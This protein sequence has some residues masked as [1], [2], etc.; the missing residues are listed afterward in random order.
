MTARITLITR[1]STMYRRAIRSLFVATTALLLLTTAACDK[2]EEKKTDKSAEKK[3]EEVKTPEPPVEPPPV[4]P[5][6]VEPADTTAVAADTGAPA[7]DT[8]EPPADDA[9]AKVDDGG[10]T[11]PAD[12]PPADKPP[13]D[14]PPADKPEPTAAKIDGKPIFDSKC[15]SCHGADGKGDTTIGK[16]VNIPSLAGTA[17]SK[18]KIIST[19]EAGVADTKMKGFKDRLSADEIDAVATYVKKL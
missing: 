12:K 4:E 8:G 10:E 19:T 9:G 3:P 11:P 6:P 14:K 2:A 13:A 16:K 15:K 1:L 5:P 7:A 17:L 18:A